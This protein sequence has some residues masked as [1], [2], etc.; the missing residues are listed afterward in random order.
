MRKK[1]LTSILCFALLLLMFIG[2]S[3]AYFSDTVYHSNVMTAGIISI[4]QTVVNTDVVIMPTLEIDRT[5]TVIN[6]GNQNCYARTLIAF[7]DAAVGTTG[8]TMVEYLNLGDSNIVIPTGAEKISIVINDVTYTVGY[9]VHLTELAF[10]SNNTYTCL[11]SI[12]LDA[13]A[14]SEWQVAA[15]EKYEILVISQATQV[16]GLTNLGAA[17]AL[18]E[19]FGTVKD[20]AQAWFATYTNP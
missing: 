9:Y 11:N 13:T 5:I 16:T 2:S 7:E 4:D 20:N 3:I 14:P 15:G 12:T 17:A 6:D 10:G 8:K 19:V 1:L 18:D